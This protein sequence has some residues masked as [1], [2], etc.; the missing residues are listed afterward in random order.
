MPVWWWTTACQVVD[1]H[2]EM[3][4]LSCYRLEL[5]VGSTYAA[6]AAVLMAPLAKQTSLPWPDEFPRI[7]WS[8]KTRMKV[9]GPVRTASYRR[10]AAITPAKNAI[11]SERKGAS[12]A[13]LVT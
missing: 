7:E 3:S 6:G 12:R 5:P 13:N 4:V 1:Q 10:R 2:E 9:E 8:D 11:A